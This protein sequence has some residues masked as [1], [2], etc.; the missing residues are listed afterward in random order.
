MDRKLANMASTI[1]S[2]SR[3][4]EPRSCLGLAAPVGLE[5]VTPSDPDGDTDGDAGKHGGDTGRAGHSKSNGRQ[6][7]ERQCPG[8]ISSAIDEGVDEVLG[9]VPVLPE[10]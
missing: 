2:K 7:G 1:L 10:S 8:L 6:G 3:D 5:A 9:V 4:G